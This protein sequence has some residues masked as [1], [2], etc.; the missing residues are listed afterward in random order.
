MAGS[1][2]MVAPY[3][4]KS[5]LATQP[6]GWTFTSRRPASGAMKPSR[7]AREASRRFPRCPGGA[8]RSFRR[9]GS[10]NGSPATAARCRTPAESAG[11]PES[12]DGAPQTGRR[13]ARLHVRRA[14]YGASGGDDR[15]PAPRREAPTTR[16][17]VARRHEMHRRP[18]ERSP[19]RS[20]RR[21]GRRQIVGV[22][23][24]EAR[25]EAHVRR[26]RRL[27]LHPDETLD[28]AGRR[29]HQ[30]AETGQGVERGPAIQLS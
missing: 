30:A 24:R 9:R 25:P 3:R 22:K 19:S 12:P 6:T 8:G 5:Q 11:A 1:Y 4:R 28:R 29:R 16:P 23:A 20:P 10:A 7:C 17:A 2:Q 26:V 27:R 13:T 21:H 18:H 14:T 15:G